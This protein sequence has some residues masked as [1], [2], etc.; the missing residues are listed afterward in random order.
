MW[1]PIAPLALPISLRIAPLLA[2]RRRRAPPTILRWDS[3]VALR[4]P[5]GPLSTRRR[6][7]NGRAHPALRRPNRKRT[8]ERGNAIGRQSAEDCGCARTC[9][10]SP[11]ADCGAADARAGRR[12]DR[13]YPRAAR[14]R[15]RQRPRDS[16]CLGGIGRNPRAVGPG[17]GHVRRANPGGPT[18]RESRRT[19]CRIAHGRPRRGSRMS[20]FSSTPKLGGDRLRIPPVALA[21]GFA[22][23]V[24]AALILVSGHDPLSAYG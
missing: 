24:G 10:R 20:P 2:L 22:A 4:S 11:G 15:A 5:V 3:I 7:P 17:T 19:Q 8:R 18:T 14:R 16:S 12:R 23:L 21:I 13:T 9:A 6:S 1:R